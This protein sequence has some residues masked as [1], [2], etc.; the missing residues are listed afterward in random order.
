MEKQEPE[1]ENS[2][3]EYAA[4]LVAK[5]TSAFTAEIDH[6]GDRL[7]YDLSEIPQEQKDK[8]VNISSQAAGSLL[9]HVFKSLGMEVG[10]RATIMNQ[11]EEYSLIFKKVKKD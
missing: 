11:D 8:L 4:I 6:E 10:I 9:F 5:F 1:I 3:I 2:A 7:L